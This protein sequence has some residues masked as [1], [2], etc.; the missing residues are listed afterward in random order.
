MKAGGSSMKVVASK[1]LAAFFN[2]T[3][4]PVFVTSLANDRAESRRLP[5][6]QI[7]TRNRAAIDKFAAKWDRPERALYFCVA[8]LRR[9]ITRR[10]KANLGEIVCLH[11][12]LDFKG[13]AD[14]REAIE[15]ALTTL[16]LPPSLQVFSGH[17]LHLYWLLHEA[18]PASDANI[19]RVEAA[20][21][22]IA[23]VLAGDPQVCECARL[24]R[25]P[26]SHN[27]KQAAWIDVTVR[28]ALNVA[29]SLD[30]IETTWLAKA[31]PLLQRKPG[32]K[33]PRN[34]ATQR[35]N[36]TP[37]DP[38][39]LLAHRQMVIPID[40]DD[41]FAQM[42][43]QGAGD[44]SIHCTQVSVTA[45][46]IQRGF[47]INVVVER[48][49]SETKRA[50]GSAGRRWNWRKEQYEIRRMCRTWLAKHPQRIFVEEIST[51]HHLVLE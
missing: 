13:I 48:V 1:F 22:R 2:R 19:E 40:V 11:T 32:T 45:A 28:N 20:L 42:Q 49:L 26:G 5:P 50:A 47:S 10:A 23:N 8:T 24:M 25:L 39:A 12:D 16:P 44:S 14:E 21:K 15:R 31:R 27:T 33:T 7:V 17:G 18:L 51:T 6:Q 35:H 30:Q 4:A 3:T 34:A 46:L 9:G 37:P 36:A 41:R 38:F 43:Y 29:Y